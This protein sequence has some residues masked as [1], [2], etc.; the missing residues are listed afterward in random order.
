M[1]WATNSIAESWTLASSN[2]F[3]RSLARR[4]ARG[5][6]IGLIL[7]DEIPLEKGSARYIHNPFCPENSVVD[8]GLPS[9][10]TDAVPEFYTTTPG[11]LRDAQDAIVKAFVDVLRD[12]PN[13]FLFVGNEYSHTDAWR[14][15]QIQTIDDAN[16][17]YGSDLL[18]V[19]MDCGG[20]GSDD[21]DGIS[22]CTPSAGR[23][24]GAF[25]PDG[26]PAMAQRDSRGDI[27]K[28]TQT[29]WG[30]FMDGA[31]SAGTRDSYSGSTTPSTVY[32]KA[33][34][35]DEHLRRFVTATLSPLEQLVPEDSVFS[36]GWDGRV[37]AG[38]EYLAFSG[39]ENAITVDLSD[40]PGAWRL[41][42]WDPESGGE[43]LDQGTRAGG[44]TATWSLSHAPSAI[45]IIPVDAD[46]PASPRN[47]SVK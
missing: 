21:S 13:V 17:L 15:R 30:R 41:L 16:M 32:S 26:R 10:D 38:V 24:D 42:E 40:A 34:D 46:I 39:T 11:P 4:D 33:A 9:C 6:L 36:T 19:T 43:P 3:A 22:P 29:F 31:A 35:Q 28:I 7:W 23:G 5:I 8:Y 45:Q 12:E 1:I 27:L 44:G 25:R 18:H 20:G 2:T 37:N 47:V 14:D